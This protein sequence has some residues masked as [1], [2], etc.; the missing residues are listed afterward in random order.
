MHLDG[1]EDTHSFLM[2]MFGSNESLSQA[3]PIELNNTGGTD[4]TYQTL[5]VDSALCSPAAFSVDNQSRRGSRLL[6]G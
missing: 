6:S 4:G 5:L 1:L 3:K 2:I